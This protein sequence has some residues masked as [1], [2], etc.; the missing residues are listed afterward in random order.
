MADK[1]RAVVF[2]GVKDM[3]VDTLDF[4]KLEMPNGKKSTPWRY[5]QAYC[6]QY[7]WQ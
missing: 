7:L 1:N 3:R 5:R 6:H 4:P 2:H